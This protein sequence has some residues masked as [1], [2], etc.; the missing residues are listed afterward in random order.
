MCLWR[1]GR[2][3]SELDILQGDKSQLLRELASILVPSCMSNVITSTKQH[4][5]KLI[6]L[7]AYVTSMVT[8]SSTC[9]KICLG[10]IFTPSRYLV[11][12]EMFLSVLGSRSSLSDNHCMISRRAEERH[13]IE[14]FIFRSREALIITKHLRFPMVSILYPSLWTSL[15]PGVSALR[16]KEALQ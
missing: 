9:S 16:L 15:L 14:T 10:S 12:V 2:T 4:L 11:C 3:G 1:L 6:A 13:L 8:Q 7:I 5:I